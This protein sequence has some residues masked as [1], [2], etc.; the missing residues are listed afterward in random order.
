M[1]EL[2][3]KFSILVNFVGVI[4][5]VSAF[6]WKTKAEFNRINMEIDEMKQDRKERWNAYETRCSKQELRNDEIMDKLNNMGGDI[7]EIK[8][9][10]AW[11]KKK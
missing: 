4:F 10:L 7:K 11:I 2:I 1:W 8:N 9:D 3:N 6:Y 5:V